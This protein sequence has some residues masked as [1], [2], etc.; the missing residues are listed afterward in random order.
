MQV[1]GPE[2]S[3]RRAGPAPPFQSEAFVSPSFT[4]A[5]LQVIRHGAGH[6][7]V[8]AAAGSGKTAT[9]VARVVALLQGGA[10]PARVRVLMF[11]RSAREDFQARLDEALGAA[12]LAAEVPVQTFHAAGQRLVRRLERERVLPVRRLETSEWRWRQ[13]AHAALEEALRSTG[14]DVPEVAEDDVETF[15]SFVELVKADVRTA[16]AVHVEAARK[17]EALPGHYVAAFGRLEELCTDHGLRSFSDLVHEPVRALMDDTALAARFRDHFDHLIVDEYQDVNEAQQ[18]FLRMVAGE[19][20]AV[21][22]VGDPDQ[23]VYQWR[24]A[25]PEYMAHRFEEDFPAAV[26]FT[27]PHTFRFGH[28]VALI[29]NHV[30]S[31]NRQR[32]AKLCLPAPGNPDTRVERVPERHPEVYREVVEQVRAAGYKLEAAA[33]LVRLYSQ[34]APL[35]LDL[36]EAGV[37]LRLEGRSGLFERG[38]IRSLLGYLH[39]AAGTLLPSGR[40]DQALPGPSRGELITGMLMLPLCGLGRREARHVA[41]QAVGE[42]ARRGNG[43]GALRRGLISVADGMPRWKGRRLRERLDLLD[44]LHH[45]RGD[46][47]AGEAYRAVTEDL[48]L[49]EAI[50][51]SSPRQEVAAD[52]ILLCQALGAFAEREELAVGAFL[53]HCEQLMARAAQWRS[54]PPAEALRVTSIHRAKGL[55]W[56]VV[57]LPGLA[58][59]RFPYLGEG[60][61]EGELEAERRLF[62]VAVTRA[63]ERLYLLHPP[64]PALETA[65]TRNQ[66]RAFDVAQAAAS[67]FLIEGRV[68]GATAAG[69]ALARG[70]EPPKWTRSDTLDAY[71]RALTAD[72]AVE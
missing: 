68:H 7:R 31:H 32:E 60:A 26:T 52:R 53:D 18:Q 69:D 62:Y 25:R 9:L 30:V 8:V 6:A 64:D 72:S 67:R 50:R 61:T 22:A 47:S 1:S 38:E 51:R 55:E 71:R 59:G 57:L 21:M 56:P 23:C 54:D 17:G 2:V 65:L 42:A 45:Y 41:E 46:V 3:D 24:G 70:D 11:N 33:V 43:Y 28:S 13:L 29:G 27:L 66:P 37:P 4:S 63:R 49:F 14:Q 40:R 39:L 36:L 58:E 44:T 35:E 20:A 12:G 10:D 34:A 48:A 5:Q 15:L 19:R 16:R